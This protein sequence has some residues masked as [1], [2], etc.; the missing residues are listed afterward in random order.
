MYVG[1]MKKYQK[2]A[3]IIK[4]SCA[5]HY[6][7]NYY[8]L[9]TT[10]HY[11]LLTL[12]A[13]V[14]HRSRGGTTVEVAVLHDALVRRMTASRHHLAA[15]V[16]LRVEVGVHEAVGVGRAGEDRGGGWGPLGGL[17]SVCSMV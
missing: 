12:I 8:T 9:H 3:I 5:S 7:H 4:T 1:R 6:T 11:T 13:L 15:A 14:H 2:E 16:G 17:N 10:H